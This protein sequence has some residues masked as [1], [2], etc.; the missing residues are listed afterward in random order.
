MTEV[1]APVRVAALQPLVVITRDI[2]TFSALARRWN[3]GTKPA[4]NRSSVPD[5][6]LFS[7]GNSLERESTTRMSEGNASVRR[8]PDCYLDSPPP[9]NAPSSDRGLSPSRA[10]R[11]LALS[12]IWARVLSWQSRRSASFVESCLRFPSDSSI[13]TESGKIRSEFEVLLHITHNPRE[14]GEPR[15]ALSIPNPNNNDYSAMT[16]STKFGTLSDA[17]RSE[18]RR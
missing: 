14:L 6:S 5:S 15:I 4:R 1:A 11:L 17:R 9:S 10:L 2:S 8:R 7:K 16:L 13:T 18:L 12:I 3:L